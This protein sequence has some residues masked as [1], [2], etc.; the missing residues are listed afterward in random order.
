MNDIDAWVWWLVGAAALGIP[1]V[2][3]AMP[4]FGMFAVG[5]V[6]AA[7][8]AGLGFGVV[9]QVLAFVVVSV[10]LIAVVRPIAAR[11][12]RQRPQLAT[13]V[14]ALK[15][16]QAVVMERVDGSGGRVKLAGE[17]WSARSLDTGRAY[18]VGQEVDVVD[19]EGATAIVI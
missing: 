2:V 11:H 8:V 17:I 6:A 10:A 13:G 16:K 3:T 4:E 9:I 14:D 19:I 7:V 1:L 18:D 5:A 12:G 15:G